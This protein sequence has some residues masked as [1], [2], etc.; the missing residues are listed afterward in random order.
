MR[1]DLT[2]MG[3][4]QRH[5]QK[6]INAV[7]EAG[8]ALGARLA[9]SEITEATIVPTAK[10]NGQ[11]RS[12]TIGWKQKIIENLLG[13]AAELEFG[14]QEKY[15]HRSDDDEAEK[16]IKDFIKYERSEALS[17]P[18]FEW[19]VKPRYTY[20]DGKYVNLVQ[21]WRNKVRVK[22]SEWKPRF[23]SY[24]RKARRLAK[25]HHAYIEK[26]ALLL[27]EKGTLTNAE[28]PQLDRTQ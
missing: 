21:E 7:H 17:I 28:I 5:E 23:D 4:E 13:H 11:V 20:R 27:V 6:W 8:H 19:D 16:L 10:Y 12:M 18:H 26:V 3:L 25:K 2:D 24:R 15:G 1:Y 22:K 14:Y 9:G